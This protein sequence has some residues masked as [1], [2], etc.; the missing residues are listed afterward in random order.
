MKYE[1]DYPMFSLAVDIA[2]I[3]TTNT[4]LL[5]RRGGDVNTG[6]LAFCGGFVD[7]NE[8]TKDAAIREL[9]EETNLELTSEDFIEHSDLVLD[10]VNRDPRS[11]VVSIVYIVY[12]N[13]RFSKYNLKAGDDA[14]SLEF[15]SIHD[16]GIRNQLAFDHH[17]IWDYLWSYL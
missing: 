11:R 2:V 14:T 9:K 10:D 13:D 5:I 6:K 8:T 17:K 7:I 1:Y 15:H 4:V 12:L 3:D 16:S